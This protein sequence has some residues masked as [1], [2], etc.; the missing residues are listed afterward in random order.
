MLTVLTNEV[1]GM[2]IV[3]SGN[4]SWDRLISLY[5]TLFF[6]FSL[7]STISSNSSFVLWAQVISSRLLHQLLF[8][9]HSRLFFPV[10]F[11]TPATTPEMFSVHQLIINADFK[12]RKFSG[13]SR[14]S[15][16]IRENTLCKSLP[17]EDGMPAKGE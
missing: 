6:A 17:G 14:I 15:R 4:V 12:S 3:L 9:G 2:V 10:G 5:N 1:H 16:S 13:S 8:A 11:A 7:R